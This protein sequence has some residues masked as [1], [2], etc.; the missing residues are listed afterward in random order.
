MLE[1]LQVTPYY[2][3]YGSMKTVMFSATFLLVLLLLGI[4]V[5]LPEWNRRFE[6]ILT[7]LIVIVSM[8]SFTGV[9]LLIAW[10]VN[11]RNLNQRFRTRQHHF[12]K[13]FRLLNRSC[14]SSRGIKFESGK[15]GA[16]ILIKVDK[17]KI[18]REMGGDV[19][20]EESD[21]LEYRTSRINALICDELAKSEIASS[22][23]KAL[24]SSDYFTDHLE[25]GNHG[26]TLANTLNISQPLD[27]SMSKEGSTP[28]KKTSTNNLM[29]DF[30]KQNQWSSQVDQEE[31]RKK[32]LGAI[33]LTDD[34]D[35]EVDFEKPANSPLKKGFSIK[36]SNAD[37]DSSAIIKREQDKINMS[38]D[39]KKKSMTT[40][41]TEQVYPSQYQG[42]LV[43][44]IPEL[45]NI[46]EDKQPPQEQVGTVQQVPAR[47]EVSV[48]GDEFKSVIEHSQFT[49]GP[50]AP[51]ERKPT[52]DDFEEAEF[53][54]ALEGTTT[55]SGIQN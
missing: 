37:L 11:S 45:E 52:T 22:S 25:R 5:Y 55:R 43:S 51:R 14:F 4:F 33:V 15:Y 30:L 42:L 23:H 35:E 41:D 13:V 6:K 2:K 46:E 29:E 32:V 12:T 27:V 24:S 40:E 34:E 44:Q 19:L 53:F 28:T 8:F 39:E 7:S 47:D 1:Y 9:I 26:D 54:S 18:M 10:C 36:F 38:F 20:N 3:T 48:A 50:A 49:G 31:L 16:Y 21:Q 17:A